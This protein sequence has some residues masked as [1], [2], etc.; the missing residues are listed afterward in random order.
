MTNIV[1]SIQ[2]EQN[3]IIRKKPYDS[4]IVNGIAGS[5]KTSIAMHRISYVLYVLKGTITSRNIYFNL[6]IYGLSIFHRQ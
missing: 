6:L 1:Q 4:V 5:G 2:A 3:A